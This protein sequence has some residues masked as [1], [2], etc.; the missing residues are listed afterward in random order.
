MTEFS[1]SL[2]PMPNNAITAYMSA[3]ARPDAALS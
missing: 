1:H 2:D 3:W